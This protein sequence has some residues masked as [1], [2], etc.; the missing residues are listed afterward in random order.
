MKKRLLV[1][2]TIVIM[3][4]LLLPAAHADG[5]TTWDP[6]N[7][8]YM[9][10]DA[11]YGIV[12]CTKMNVRNQPSTSGS[13]YGSIRNG[14]PVKILG[15]TQD[16]NFY[17]LDL[18][19]CGISSDQYYGYA[20]ASLIKIDPEY[21]IASRLLNLYAT[22]WG[23]GMKNGEQTNRAFLVI[24]EE[25]GWYA[26]QATETTP[27]TAFI[28]TKDAPANYTGRYIVTWDTDLY[29]DN[30]IA[31]YQSVKRFTVGSLI[32]VSGDYSR[33]LF[34]EG[35]ANEFYAWVYNQYLAPVIN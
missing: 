29:D 34:N 5:Y 16:G 18:A 2:I 25:N 8:A 15:V 21:L 32:G 22:P 11:H 9:Y 17:L 31:K 12:I 3:L 23:D 30:T 20:K 1:M 24:S 27:G 14:Q 7:Q 4:M 19:S 26:V 35:T 6:V 10:N 28:R 13:T 33:M